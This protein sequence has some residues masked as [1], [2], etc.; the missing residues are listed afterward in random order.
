MYI[1]DCW[2]DSGKSGVAIML[3]RE[4]HPYNWY[5]DV[6]EALCVSNKCKIHLQ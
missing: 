2:Y 3:V 5:V 1:Y 6:E 4:M